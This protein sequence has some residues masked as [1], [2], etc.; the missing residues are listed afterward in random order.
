MKI[1]FNE[2]LLSRGES[3]PEPQNFQSDANEL[4][5]Q[6]KQTIVQA[7]QS[8]DA[9][10]TKS[11]KPSIILYP[12]RNDVRFDCSRMWLKAVPGF[13]KLII[14]FDAF[15]PPVYTT[16]IEFDNENAAIR[17]RCQIAVW[18]FSKRSGLTLVYKSVNSENESI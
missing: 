1:F 18:S 8:R 5:T 4:T 16:T 10:N 12:S 7:S 6:D 13:L 17:K 9:D 11:T 15:T 3:N 14:D 2:S